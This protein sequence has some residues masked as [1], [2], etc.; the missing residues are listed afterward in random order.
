LNKAKLKPLDRHELECRQSAMCKY[1]GMLLHFYV[2]IYLSIRSLNPCW[3][4]LVS[5]T[6]C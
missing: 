1:R 2:S 3:V 6:D 4:D 5:G